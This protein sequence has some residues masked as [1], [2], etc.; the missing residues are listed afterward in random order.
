MIRFCVEHS[1]IIDAPA[2]AVYQVLAD[3]NHGHAQIMPPQFFEGMTV[4]KGTG[5]GEGTRIEARFRVYGQKET[6]LM[7]VS[8]PEPGRVLQE[9]DSKAVNITRFIVDPLGGQDQ[10]KC[11]VTLQT[12]V[13]KSQ[14]ML[15]GLDMWLKRMVL[16]NL[17]VQELKLLN[18]YMQQQ[19]PTQNDKTP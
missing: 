11:R 12:K 4:V 13:M 14:G 5:V 8:E 1:S 3:Y 17:F 6:L 9:I 16:T 19:Q 15:A 10:D 2:K 18:Q 7:D